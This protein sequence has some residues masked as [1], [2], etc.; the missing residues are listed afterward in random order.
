MH[1]LERSKNSDSYRIA[2]QKLLRSS[3]GGKHSHRSFIAFIL[4]FSAV[5]ILGLNTIYGLSL[6]HGGWT[7]SRSL[8]SIFIPNYGETDLVC[9]SFEQEQNLYRRHSQKMFRQPP[10]NEFIFDIK[11]S[12][13]V[14]LLPLETPKILNK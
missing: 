10:K 2:L 4:V 9:Y 11:L 3:F 13:L 14:K 7:V 6:G 8:L 12:T 5:L 1:H